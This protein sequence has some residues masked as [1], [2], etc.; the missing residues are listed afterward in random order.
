MKFYCA[1][2]ANRGQQFGSV[3]HFESQ[4]AQAL[5]ADFFAGKAV[6]FDEG[7]LP[8]GAGE[9]DTGHAAAGAAA[10]DDYGGHG[11]VVNRT[12]DRGRRSRLYKD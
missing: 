6:L 9:Q 8:T 7:D 11:Y 1:G 3:Q 12:A 2:G 5:A 10:D 4:R